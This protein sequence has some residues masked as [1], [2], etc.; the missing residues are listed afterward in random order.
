[1]VVITCEQKM[2]YVYTGDICCLV[3]CGV[4]TLLIGDSAIPRPACPG[5]AVAW[6]YC[7]DR[8]IWSR[9]AYGVD[10]RRQACEAA[11][12]SSAPR[13]SAHAYHTP[14]SH[15]TS[16]PS[17]NTPQSTIDFSKKIIKYTFITMWINITFITIYY[18][19][20]LKTK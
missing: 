16:T 9:H 15:N 17:M 1:M 5:A 13:S 19:L 11:W 18:N 4:W 20:K 14:P 7:C 3:Y 8:T 6:K 2:G 12:Q 10:G